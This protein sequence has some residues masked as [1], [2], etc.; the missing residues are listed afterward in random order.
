MPPKP[1]GKPPR[2]S[3][4]PAAAAVTSGS[5]AAGGGAGGAK[6]GDGSWISK[7]SPVV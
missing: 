6:L 3:Y 4:N 2:F 5:G 7:G 1:T